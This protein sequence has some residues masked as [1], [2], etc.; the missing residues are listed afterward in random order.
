M[1]YRIFIISLA[2]LLIIAFAVYYYVFNIYEVTVKV[3][4]PNLFADN[5]SRITIRVIPIN[6]L[7]KRAPFRSVNAKFII[8]QGKDLID[9][10]EQDENNGILILRSKGKEGK[11]IIIVKSK[12]S[13]LP[14]EVDIHVVANYAEK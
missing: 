2:I 10:I 1:K 13:L 4:P 8:T 14:T 5:S 7:G 9:V 12:Y 11:V 6:A 3:T